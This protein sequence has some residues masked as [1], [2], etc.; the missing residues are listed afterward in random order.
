MQLQCNLLRY[1]AADLQEEKM[2]CITGLSSAFILDL[3][4]AGSRKSNAGLSEVDCYILKAQHGRYQ[5]DGTGTAQ[6][7]R[8][9]YWTRLRL[10]T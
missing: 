8:N 5:R 4:I 10:H 6:A 3:Q 9:G 1:A 2:C 7:L